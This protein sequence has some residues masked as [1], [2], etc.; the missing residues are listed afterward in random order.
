VDK[1]KRVRSPAYPAFGLEDCIERARAIYEAEDRHFAPLEAAAAHWGYKTNNS[2]FLQY[3]SSLKQ[4][5][6]LT[7]EGS[8]EARK[9][10]LTD[11]ALD[12]LAYDRSHEKWQRAVK[13]AA[14]EPKIHR[15]LWEKYGGKLP[16]EDVSIRVYLI[17]ERA[18][19]LFN[20]DHVDG[21]ISQ[22][23]STIA[24]S[25][26]TSD[27]KID[28]EQHEDE[29]VDVEDSLDN[30]D[31]DEKPKKPNAPKR[32]DW[33]GPVVK[34]DLPRGNMVEIRLRSKLSPTEFKNLKKIFDLSELAFVEEA[35]AQQQEGADD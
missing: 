32:D 21:F 15:E 35:S 9:F 11:R 4:F 29:G 17:R 26:L 7:E 31:R 23:R 10:R 5:G 28:S 18:D 1:K 24:F 3:L 2:A 19:G 13:A 34:F 27:D 30:P 12:L 25:G 6:L 14:L 33:A 22:F 20:K 16:R 8:G